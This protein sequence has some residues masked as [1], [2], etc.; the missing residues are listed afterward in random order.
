M[1]RSFTTCSAGKIELQQARQLRIAVLF[2]H[3]NALVRRHKV[4]NLVRKRIRP[5]AHVIHVLP[6]FFLIWSRLSR[7]A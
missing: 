4:V 2:H 3:V 6:V 7:I 5:D 1:L